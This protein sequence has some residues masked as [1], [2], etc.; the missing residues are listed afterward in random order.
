MLGRSPAIAELVKAA[1]VDHHDIGN[2]GVADPLGQIRI[3][4]DRQPHSGIG[5]NAATLVG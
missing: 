3:R 1:V 2:T 4:H 5:Q